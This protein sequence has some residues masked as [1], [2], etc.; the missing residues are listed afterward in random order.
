MCDIHTLCS[1]P[2][3]KTRYPGCMKWPHISLGCTHSLFFPLCV[4][5]CVAKSSQVVLWACWLVYDGCLCGWLCVDFDWKCNQL[6]QFKCIT[7]RQWLN[8]QSSF[9]KKFV[10]FFLLEQK[11]FIFSCDV[12]TFGALLCVSPLMAPLL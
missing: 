2:C 7:N 11:A 10:F 1:S 3:V 4:F 6:R 12:I 5:V 9:L 8:S